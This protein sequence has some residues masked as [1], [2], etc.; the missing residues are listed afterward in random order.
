MTTIRDITSFLHKKAPFETAE[1]WDNSGLLV[2]DSEAPVHTVY[3]SLD[4]TDETVSGA[5]DAGAQLMIS[6]HPVIFDPL[7]SLPSDSTVYRL[8]REGIAA[9]CVHTNLDKCAGG[10][11][12]VLAKTIG[13]VD[14]TVSEDGMS[15]IGRLENAM[16]ATEF[17][18][19]V[20]ARL[21]TAVRAKLGTTEVR[22]VALCGGAGAELVLPLLKEA[23]AAV[24]SELKH[25]EWLGIDACKTVIDGGHFETETGVMAVVAAWLREEF[26]ELTVI[27][28]EQEPPYQTIKD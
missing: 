12:D 27:V 5:V 10:V 16:T 22:T 24:T 3:L 26:P 23:D 9:L 13:L 7:K 20:S 25:H 2:G 4:I 1:D 21:R 17:A 15:R 8:A 11:N 14:V 19:C 6:H 18:N 28:G